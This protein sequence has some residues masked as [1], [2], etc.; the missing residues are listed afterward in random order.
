[1]LFSVR[2]FWMFGYLLKMKWTHSTDKEK[3]LKIKK[4]AAASSL[5]EAFGESAPQLI[6]QL[7]IALKLGRFASKYCMKRLLV[8]VRFRLR[9]LVTV[10]YK[11]TKHYNY[12]QTYLQASKL[13]NTC[14]HIYTNTKV[15]KNAKLIKAW[16]KLNCSEFWA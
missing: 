6:L 8:T 14:T 15:L 16:V 2:S 13:L 5:S 11:C 3:V 10:I 1:L 7:T 9:L 12:L 4:E